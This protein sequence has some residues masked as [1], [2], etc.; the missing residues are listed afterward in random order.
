MIATFREKVRTLLTMGESP[1]KL[2]LAFAVGVF[3]AFSPLIGAH[4]AMAAV[5]VW[6][7]RFNPIAIFMGAFI[8]NPWTFVPIYAA[9]LWLGMRLSPGGGALPPISMEG[10]T[11]SGFLVQFKPYLMPFVV[12]TTVVGVVAA[13]AGYLA[14]VALIKAYRGRKAA[15]DA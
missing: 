3:I 5:S 10:L 6:A 8:N 7:F 14:M 1:H 2:G 4:T 12:G 11:F 15:S 13:V 9:C